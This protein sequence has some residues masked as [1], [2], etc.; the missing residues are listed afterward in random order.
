LCRKPESADLPPLLVGE[1]LEVHIQGKMLENVVRIP[2]EFLRKNN[3]AWIMSDEDKLEIRELDIIFKDS[4]YAYLAS[5]IAEGERIITSSLSRVTEGAELRVEDE[6]SA[7][8][9]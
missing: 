4:S 3:T 8:N 2:I 1:F 5:G 9:E 6:N 7:S